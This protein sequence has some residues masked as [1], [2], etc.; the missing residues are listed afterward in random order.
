MPKAV[1]WE[2]VSLGVVGLCMRAESRACLCGVRGLAGKQ[3]LASERHQHRM[4]PDMCCVEFLRP[5]VVS[6]Q[7]WVLAVLPTQYCLTS[8]VGTVPLFQCVGGGGLHGGA[9]TVC[10]QSACDNL[11]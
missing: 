1:L 4:E 5:T 11:K 7:H 2:R 6:C 8:H 9:Y 3:A 10:M